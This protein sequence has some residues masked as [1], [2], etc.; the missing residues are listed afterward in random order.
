MTA[1]FNILIVEDEIL[2][3]NY[4]KNSIELVNFKCIGIAKSYDETILFLH[5]QNDIDLILLDI[6]LFGDKTGIDIAKILNDK[7]KIPFVYLTS[8]SDQNTVENIKETFPLGY[9]S[10]PINK[11]NML[12]NL[13]IICSNLIVKSNDFSF[14]IGSVKHVINLND[15]LYVR[16]DHVYLEIVLVNEQLLLRSSL[17]NILEIFS[18]NYL[19]QVNRSVAV[20]PNYIVKVNKKSVELPNQTFKLSSNFRSNFI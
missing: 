6:S 20:N 7:Y 1:K 5:K 4:I 10:K 9:L 8:F 18:E 14:T 2:I 19:Q 3:A 16:S 17:K 12:T 13:Q 15:L 11:I